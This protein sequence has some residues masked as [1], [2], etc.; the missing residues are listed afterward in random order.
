MNQL[1]SLFVDLDGTLT[2]SDTLYEQI[3]LLLRT[4]PW[5]L[6]RIPMWLARGGKARLKHE[7]GVLAPLRVENLPY[8]ARVL[9]YISEHRTRG[10]DAYLATAASSTTAHAVAN[11]IG[12]FDGV[13]CS[14]RESNLSGHAKLESIRA[15][16][17][18]FSYIGNGNV[19]L[20]IWKEADNKIIVNAP[21]PLNNK[22]VSQGGVSLGKRDP[23]ITNLLRACRP[24]QWLKN[25]LLF[26]PLLLAHELTNVSALIDSFIGFLSFSFCASGVYLLNDMLDLEHDRGHP[27][28]KKRPFAAGLLPIKTGVV[29]WMLITAL[30]IGLAVSLNW[31]FLIILLGYL[32]I[33]NAYSL[34]LKKVIM[35]DVAVL[36]GLYT[37]RVVA[38]SEAIDVPLSFW[39]LSFSMFLFLSLALVKRYCEIARLKL[40]ST[41]KAEG[42]GYEASDKW[43]IAQLGTSSGML[44]VLVLALYIN[45]N[46]VATSYSEPRFIWLICPLLMYWIGRIWLLAHRGEVEEDPVVFAAKDK[47]TWLVGGLG[48]LVFALAITQ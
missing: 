38:G 2:K 3:F 10:G 16:H 4:R 1:A 25:L 44:S 23:V 39:L 12:L 26:V 22:I 8:N 37:V 48:A 40:T 11:H 30:G 32:L 27:T 7:V 36:A 35:L 5:A 33:T 34:R 47:R 14:D 17:T 18:Q 28:K 43:I 15:Q 46:V 9:D 31:N 19:D 41:A 6:I 21:P 45:S 24:H 20:P 42:R 13:L 29:A